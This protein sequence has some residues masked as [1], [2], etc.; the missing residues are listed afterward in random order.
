MSIYINVP[1]FST[2]M[3]LCKQPSLE[4][5]AFGE[6]LERDRLA[7]HP[8]GQGPLLATRSLRSLDGRRLFAL[9]TMAKQ[10]VLSFGRLHM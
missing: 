5:L 4:N 8:M 7:L 1:D 6:L 9:P 2:V 3:F 10:K